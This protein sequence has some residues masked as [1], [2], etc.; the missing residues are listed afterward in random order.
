MLPAAPQKVQH[1][2]FKEVRRPE[3][4][5]GQGRT[6]DY[7]SLAAARKNFQKRTA[8]QAELPKSARTKERSPSQDAQI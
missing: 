1:N 3:E 6:L 2:V 5:S 7:L 4:A 8:K